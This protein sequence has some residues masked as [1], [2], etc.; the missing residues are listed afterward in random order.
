MTQM[1]G[2]AITT[3]EGEAVGVAYPEKGRVATLTAFVT[4]RE[5]GDSRPGNEVRATMHLIGLTEA[6]VMGLGSRKLLI[7]PIE[8]V[9]R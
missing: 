9:E 5:R 6:E 8:G 2:F 3:P 1:T 4:D 7:V